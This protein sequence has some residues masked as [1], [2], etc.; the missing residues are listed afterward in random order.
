MTGSDVNDLIGDNVRAARRRLGWS[1]EDLISKCA[2]EGL[3]LTAGQMYL[4]EARG[5]D[6][7]PRRRITVDELLTL[8]RVF[9]VRPSVL[10]PELAERTPSDPD[11]VIAHI[12]DTLPPIT[13]KQRE[14]LVAYLHNSE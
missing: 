10:L 13:E 14:S 2:A 5:K 6:G 4:I 9:K 12:L 11:P 3:T 1:V 8:A 7:R